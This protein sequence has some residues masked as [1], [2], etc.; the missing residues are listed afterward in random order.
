[1][2]KQVIKYL[3]VSGFVLGIVCSFMFN[4]TINN[5]RIENVTGVNIVAENETIYQNYDY[6]IN[7]SLWITLFWSKKI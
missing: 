7:N 6:I 2:Q 5:V 1:M 4:N 3:G